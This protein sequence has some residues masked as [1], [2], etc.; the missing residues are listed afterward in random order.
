[1]GTNMMF[2]S[3]LHLLLLTFAVI[4]SV[5]GCASLFARKAIERFAAGM[6]EQDLDQLK[7]ITSR[8]FNEKALR[9]PEATKD[10]KFLRVPGGKV[11]IVSLEKVDGSEKMH[12]AVVKVGEKE[13]AQ[14]LEY[15]L[16]ISPDTGRWVVHDVILAQDSGR[17]DPIRRSVSEQMDLLLTCREF[18][19]TWKEG[20][21]TDKLDF[22]HEE[23]RAELETLPPNWFARLSQEAVGDGRQRTFRPE[24]RL[25]GQRAV[26]VVP[27][28]DGSLFLELKQADERWW[29]HDLAIEP[30]SKDSTGI[31]SLSKVARSLN[32]SA[33][34]LS[35]YASENREGLEAVSTANFYEKCLAAADLE[36]VPLPVP[37]LLASD[38]EAKQFSDRMELLFKQED[39]T[40]MLTLRQE[41]RER[42][43]G[44]KGLAESRVDEVTLFGHG[45]EEVKRVSAMF[46]SHSIVNVYIQALLDRDLPQLQKL[47]TASF[48]DRVWNRNFAR[49]F[50]ILPYPDL[51]PEEIEVLA[52]AFHGNMTEVTASVGQ[53]PMTFILH[54]ARGWLVVDDVLLPSHDR[55]TSL[56]TNLE[57]MLPLYSFA[58]AVH[59]RDVRLVMKESAEAFNR[60]VWLQLNHVPDEAR[61]LVRPLMSE[62]VAIERGDSWT[63][64]RTTDGTT[65][66]EVKLVRAG[67][68]YV[69]HDVALH[70]ETDPAGSLDFMNVMRQMIAS[71]Q[72]HARPQHRGGVQHVGGLTETPSRRS[73]SPVRQAVHESS[74]PEPG[75]QRTEPV[76]DLQPVPAR[77]DRTV[78]EPIAPEIYAR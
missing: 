72:V 17:G 74:E 33:K 4:G 36:Q 52:T 25:N 28:P 46:L 51:G 23:L 76:E 6:Q 42:K 44:T 20:K 11:E 16:T 24:A 65:T 69:V 3:R 10:L 29:V 49:H 73:S 64:V 15:L 18:L 34:F 30:K 13:K 66:A 22:C 9:Q 8:E 77:E 12:K 70:S 31:R 14:E 40:Y 41:E 7:S 53:T 62:V 21:R 43:D 78:F 48:N 35:A 71:G 27:H 2:R 59:K 32:R 55:P 60:M 61:Q 50:S 38:Y 1:M 37:A 63:I 54:Q 26:V 75:M 57:L 5:S 47:S 68:R 67:Q 56:K 58:S 45:G 19:S 39:V